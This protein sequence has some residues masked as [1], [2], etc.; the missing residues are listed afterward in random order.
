MSWV[1]EYNKD[2]QKEVYNMGLGGVLLSVMNCHIYYPGKWA[3]SLTPL[4][5]IRELNASTSDEA[6]A[7]AIK[8]AKAVIDPIY[9][10]LRD[11]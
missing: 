1:K 3:A 10:K 5:S 4:T 7:E 6:K 8:M 11:A 9:E 2:S